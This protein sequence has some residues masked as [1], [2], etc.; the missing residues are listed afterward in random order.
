MLVCAWLRVCTIMYMPTCMHVFICAFICMLVRVHM[1]VYAPRT[2]GSLRLGKN[3]QPSGPLDSRGLPITFAH[4]P[5]GS[6][7]SYPP[8]LLPKSPF[9]PQLDVCLLEASLTT[10]G[11][12]SKP[13]CSQGTGSPFVISLFLPTWGPSLATRAGDWPRE[14]DQNPCHRSRLLKVYLSLQAGSAPQ[15]R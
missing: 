9:R 2:Q 1:C 15:A 8:H 14:V 4:A 7:Y 13:Q 5:M 6:L 11:Q 10:Q 12:S 3:Q